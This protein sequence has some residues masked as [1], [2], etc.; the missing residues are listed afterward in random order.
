M[1]WKKFSRPRESFITEKII[2]LYQIPLKHLASD[3]IVRKNSLSSLIIYSLPGTFS[4]AFRNISTPEK[5][6]RRN[7][8]L[9]TERALE[10][11]SQHLDEGKMQT[12]F[13]IK[14]PMQPD[15]A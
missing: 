12:C 9:I 10:K 3:P 1:E 6:S 4:I 13:S 11:T 5:E 2:K 14:S 8:K 15:S 7:G